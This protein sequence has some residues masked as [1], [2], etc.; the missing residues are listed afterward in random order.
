M[1][2]GTNIIALIKFV[3]LV[4]ITYFFMQ[5]LTNNN[6]KVGIVR[7][8]CSMCIIFYSI[9]NNSNELNIRRVNY[10]LH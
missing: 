4:I 1:I 6:K 8:N 3:A 9:Y 5:V 10:Y 7:Y 2:I